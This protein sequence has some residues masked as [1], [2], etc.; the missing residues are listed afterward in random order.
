M[1][2]FNATLSGANFINVEADRMEVRENML[3]VWSGVSW[4]PWLK[5]RPSSA[6]TSAKEE[7]TDEGQEVFMKTAIVIC[8]CVFAAIVIVSVMACCK[9]SGDCAREEERNGW[10]ED[11]K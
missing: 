10:T 5:S 2:K 7:I 3:W 11:G 9:I 8:C 4:L 6:H 1:K